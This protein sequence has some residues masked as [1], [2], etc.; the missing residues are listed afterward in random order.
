MLLDPPGFVC[1]AC[2]ECCRNLNEKRAVFLNSEDLAR[3]AQSLKISVRDFE[4][5]YCASECVEL[6]E[7]GPRIVQLA[8]GADGNCPFL[9]E[10]GLCGIHQVKPHQCRATPYNFFFEASAFAY[11]CMKDVVVPPDWSSDQND[12]LFIN[13]LFLA[14]D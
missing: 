3:I 1:T 12:Q 2:G 14:Q 8:A 9:K 11:D 10:D 13:G 7:G 5:R 4:H 6:A